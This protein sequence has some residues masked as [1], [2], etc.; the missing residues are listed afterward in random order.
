[1]FSSPLLPRPKKLNTFLA[2]GFISSRQKLETR[3]NINKKLLTIE[4]FDIL[5][6][7]QERNIGLGTKMDFNITTLKQRKKSLMQT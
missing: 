7:T 5:V 2:D 6:H 3:C 4:D 1:M